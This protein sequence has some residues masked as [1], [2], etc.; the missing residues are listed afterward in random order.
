MIDYDSKELI[1]MPIEYPF[2]FNPNTQKVGQYYARDIPG[3]KDDSIWND[4][5]DDA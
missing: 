4:R 5:N 3:Y 1:L 2:Y